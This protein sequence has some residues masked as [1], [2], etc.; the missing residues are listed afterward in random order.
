MAKQELISAYQFAERKE[1]SNTAVYRAI[2][3]GDI[4]TTP[5]GKQNFIDWNKFKDVSFNRANKLKAAKEAKQ[6]PSN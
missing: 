4:I 1:V 5:V 6:E 2:E 3:R